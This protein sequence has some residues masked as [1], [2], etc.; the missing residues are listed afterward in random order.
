MISTSQLTRS[1]RLAL[2]HRNEA[3][4]DDGTNPIHSESAGDGTNPIRLGR[5]GDGTNPIEPTKRTQHRR[6]NKP[7]RARVPRVPS[8]EP[9]RSMRL[10]A[11]VEY[12]PWHPFLRQVNP[13]TAWQRNE[14]NGRDGTNPI[15]TRARSETSPTPTAERSQSRRRNEPNLPRVPFESNPSPRRNEPNRA[16]GTKPKSAPERAQRPRRNEPNSPASPGATSSVS[17]PMRLKRLTS[18]VE[19]NPWH[20]MPRPVNPMAAWAAKRTQRLRRNE[21]NSFGVRVHHQSNAAT[22][23]TQFALEPRS[24]VG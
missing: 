14:P 2:A 11:R 16:G 5:A 15:R 18:R 3:N 23:R 6:R 9:V 24:S 21:P 22:E 17:E 7:N 13:M 10:T 8:S 4:V 19:Y 1:T 20:S 12:N